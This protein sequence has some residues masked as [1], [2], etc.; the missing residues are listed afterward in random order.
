M[1]FAILYA[2]REGQTRRVAE[3]LAD[4]LRTRGAAVDVFDVA[5]L[6]V[7]FEL[8]Q[9]GS[10]VLA[11]SV[12]AGK[13][14][15]EMIKFVKQQRERL[16][17]V[18]TTLLSL[19]LS[20][21]GAERVEA[22]PEARAKAERDVRMMIDQ[23]IVGTSFHPTRVKPVAGALRYS[24]YNPIVRLVMKQIAKHSGGSTD[25]RH[26]HEY[27]D[28]AA[29]EHLADELAREASAHT[30]ARAAQTSPTRKLRVVKGQRE[31]QG[32]S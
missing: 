32:V 12:H 27:T 3:G 5:H 4:M 31:D 6:P 2:T 8:S 11:A 18:P 23:F 20:E 15:P 7:S 16:E 22:T 30:I 14:E 28:W 26:D 1:T 9:F 10:V 21:A 24:K 29:L 25:T 19:S 17:R 13:H